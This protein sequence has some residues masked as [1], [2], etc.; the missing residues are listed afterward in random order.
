MPNSDGTPKAGEPGYIAP[1]TG[2]L[3]ATPNPAAAPPTPATATPATASTYDP[4]KYVMT[5][6]Q[7]VEGRT[8]NLVKDDSVLM[9]QARTRANQDAQAKGLLSS[10][11]AV[12][13]GQ[14]AV[15]DK[16]LPI[17]SQDAAT[18]NAAMTNTVNAENQSKQF[19][20]GNL[21][22]VSKTNAGLLTNVAQSNAEITLK[23]YLSNLDSQT[24]QLLQTNAN[25][26][27]MYQE[28]VR[29]IAAIAV[30]PTLTPAAKNAATQTQMNLMTE[31][32]RTTAG[33]ASTLPSEVQNLNLDSYFQTASGGSAAAFTPEQKATQLTNLNSQITALQAQRADVAKNGTGVP[34]LEGPNASE[35][36]VP[37]WNQAIADLDKQIQ[38]LQSQKAA[39]A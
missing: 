21:T 10:S 17:A 7:T 28:T 39:L 18:A 5:P 8:A 30:D 14:N 13:A 19:N 3:T 12:G 4:S 22:D 20:A 6:D 36:R 15:L 27:Q 38:E 23:T 37:L 1:Q 26:Q 11:I 35:R 9:Q 16:A 34:V 33:I 25:A 32:L 31:G 24:R 29:N 2:L